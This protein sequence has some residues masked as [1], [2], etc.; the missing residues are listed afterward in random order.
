MIEPSETRLMLLILARLQ[1]LPQ[2]YFFRANT[3]AARVAGGRVVRFGE[4]GQ[5]DIIGVL[6]GRFVG[7]ETKTKSGRLSKDQQIWG[8]RVITAGGVYIVAKSLDDVM[9]A[10]LP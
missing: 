10:L 4:K 7:V 9:S 6:C 8:E 5:A 3:G 1:Q 2:S